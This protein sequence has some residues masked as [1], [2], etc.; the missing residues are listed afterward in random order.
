MHKLNEKGELLIPLI[1]VGVLL[2]GSLAFGFWAFAGRQDY[3]NNT[4]QKIAEAVKA[5]EEVLTIKKDAEFA[6]EQKLPHTSYTGPAA[7]G[8]LDITYPKTWSVYV[9]EDGG[10]S[11]PLNGYM[12][13]RYVMADGDS[14]YALRFQVLGQ[15]YDQALKQFESAVRQ[16]KVSVAAY[17]LPKVES[18]AGSRLQGEV[19]SKKQGVMILMPLR[20]KTLKLW[21]EGSEYTSDFETILQNFTFIP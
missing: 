8:T 19:V 15:A 21:T 11:Q 12:H 7:Y 14:S 16:G 10:N 2:L 3:K 4:D 18:V 17:R 5:A 20:D 6:E 1:V 13:P 9:D